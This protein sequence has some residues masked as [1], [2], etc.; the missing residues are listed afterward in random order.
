MYN[1]TIRDNP[2]SYIGKTVVIR[3]LNPDDASIV[4]LWM[5]EKFFSY[6]KPYLKRICSS[7]SFLAQRI[8][9]LAYLD[10]P[11]EIEALVLH[12]SSNVPLGLVS[13]SNIDTINLKA[14]FS[15]AFSRGL[16]TRCVPETLG[17]LF[18]YVF[19]TLKLNKLY[20]YIT[21]DN[22]RILKMIQHYH[23]LQEGK[24]CKE[25]LS[26]NGEWLDMYRFGIL[27]EDWMQ[28]PLNKK[29]RNIAKSI[30]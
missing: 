4:Y 8:E 11:F 1:A 12:R 29:L 28:S 21:S 13:L 6:Y 27:L 23:V 19:F 7:A 10:I 2:F 17:F 5:Q 14:E 15:I 9:T 22:N 24:L 18:Q 25:V 26:E 30:R 16:G 20:F 3:T